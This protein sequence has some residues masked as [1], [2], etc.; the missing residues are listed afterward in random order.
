M[1][2][3]SSAPRRG[4]R[5]SRARPPL[6]TPAAFRAS[7]PQRYRDAFDGAAIREHAAIVARRG[8]APAHVQ[9]WRR[10]P[11]GGAIACVVADDRPGLLSF[12]SAALAVEAMDVTAA[13]AYTRALPDGRGAEA[14]DFLWL[15]RD[16]SLQ[17]PVRS[18]TAARVAQI[19][20]GLIT[21]ELTIESVMRRARPRA[22]APAGGATR[23]AF[24]ES[25]DANLAV[26]TI[27]TFDRPRLLLAITMALFRADVQVIA[28]DVT[29]THG[30]VVDRF[31]IAELDG[32]PV[33]R[34][35]RGAVQTAVLA[36]IDS[37]LF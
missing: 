3:A 7:M 22:K 2:H 20:G 34:H 17:T 9:I 26:L 32:S 6:D 19:L 33:L 5:E 8:S 16:G 21:G 25:S 30:R 10:L 23:V 12:I 27:E 35:R 37:V 15:R 11:K 24:D 18:D 31:T 36:A 29:T 4:A 14:V 13:Q 1:I 28:S